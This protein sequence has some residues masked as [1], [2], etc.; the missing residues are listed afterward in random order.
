MEN[1]SILR[2][3]EGHVMNL[4][5]SCIIFGIVFGIVSAIREDK[6]KPSPEELYKDQV[7][8][9]FYNTPEENIRIDKANRSHSF[10]QS[11]LSDAV[12]ALGVLALWWLC[13]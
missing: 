1:Y 12:L 5:I 9:L 11:L 13:L 10:F 7:A 8:T 6:N 4:L 2:E 3:K